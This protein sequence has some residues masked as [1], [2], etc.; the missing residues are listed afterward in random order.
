MRRYPEALVALDEAIAL[1]PDNTKFWEAKGQTLWRLWRFGEVWKVAKHIL[2][3]REA[4]Q[5][6]ASR[7][8]S[9]PANDHGVS[10]S[11]Q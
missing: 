3:L 6:K 5:A 11:K 4:E 8:I 1:E 7:P 9:T 2:D 10:T